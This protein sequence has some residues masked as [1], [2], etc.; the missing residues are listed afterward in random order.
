M[1]LFFHTVPPYPTPSLLSRTTSPYGLSNL[2]SHRPRPTASLTSAWRT[3]WR[4]RHWSAG[5]GCGGRWG[6]SRPCAPAVP[7]GT[8]RHSCP[9]APRPAAASKPC[10]QCCPRGRS[11]SPSHTPAAHSTRAHPRYPECCTCRKNKKL[12]SA[13]ITYKTTMNKDEHYQYFLCLAQKKQ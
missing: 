7:G 5:R 6:P 2:I 4:P 8:S 1:D 3:P 12:H 10:P 11:S 13:Q 9:S